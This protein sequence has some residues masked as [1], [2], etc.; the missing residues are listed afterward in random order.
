LKTYSPKPSDIT[1]KWFIVDANGLVLGR[2]ATKIAEVLRGKHK[3]M[4][5]PH[6]DCGDF[7]VVV[8]ADKVRI[9]GRKMLQKRYVHH[10]GYPG[11]LRHTPIARVMQDRPEFILKHAVRGM[12]PHNRLGRQMLKKL[13]IYTA[14]EH[15]HSAQQPE[16]LSV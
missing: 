1:Q 6:M 5:A 7:I 8:N 3:P 9:T 15:P 13:K 2:L 14:P 12:L 10:T 4:W 11:G 16:P